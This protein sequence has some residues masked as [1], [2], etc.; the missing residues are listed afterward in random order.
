[1]QKLFIFSLLIIFVSACTPTPDPG[2]GQNLAV[3]NGCTS[4]HSV[5]DITK[6]AP[7][8]RGLYGSQIELDNGNKITVNDEYL[9]E[10]IKSPNAKIVKG[11][12]KGAMPLIDLTEEEI[13]NLVAYIKSVK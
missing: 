13:A 1:L 12:T 9:I 4:C 5:D 7:P 8:W 11:Y 10:S 3:L 2:S 6:I